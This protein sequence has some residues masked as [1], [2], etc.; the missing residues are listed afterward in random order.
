MKKNVKL[1]LALVLAFAL[2]LGVSSSA[3]ADLEVASVEAPE[4]ELEGSG[5]SAYIYSAQLYAAQDL[6]MTFFVRA[7]NINDATPVMSITYVNGAQEDLAGT[8]D[9]SRDLY[10]FRVEKIGSQ[11]MKDSFTL[12]VK[13]DGIVL[14]TKTY[15]IAQYLEALHNSTAA[16]LGLSASKYSALQTLVADILEYGAA[17]QIYKNHNTSDLA[18]SYSWVAGLKT[19]TAGLSAPASV[20]SLSYETQSNAFKAAYLRLSGKV[21]IGFRF[22]AADADTVT[23]SDGVNSNTILVNTLSASSGVYTIFTDWLEIDAFDKTF[24][25]TLTDGGSHTYST[26]TYSVNSYLNRKWESDN[27]TLVALV[28]ALTAYNNS[29]RAYAYAE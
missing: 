15:S 24:T 23:M 12:D 14:D 27:D 5:P 9:A 16:K 11:N 3:L 4:I 7:S 6:T 28:K 26:L 2:L 17:A 1:L 25:V 18:N 8:Y 19:N 22:I 10:L 29:A 21:R 20:Q 13:H